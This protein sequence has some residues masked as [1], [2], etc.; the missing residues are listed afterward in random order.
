MSLGHVDDK[1]LILLDIGS[2]TPLLAL[3]SWFRTFEFETQKTMGKWAIQP[4]KSD[5]L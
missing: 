4:R 2:P 3:I 5:R 1:T